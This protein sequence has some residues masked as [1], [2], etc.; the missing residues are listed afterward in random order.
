MLSL[1]TAKRSVT[2]FE[3]ALKDAG[4]EGELIFWQAEADAIED[5]GRPGP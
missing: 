1:R 5:F 4:W 3:L 2:G